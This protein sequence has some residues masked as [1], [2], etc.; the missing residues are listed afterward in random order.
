MD[1]MFAIVITP[2]QCLR[3]IAYRSNLR[4]KKH[5][6]AEKGKKNHQFDSH[7]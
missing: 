6:F 7:F 1:S 3:G 4:S 5:R 2:K